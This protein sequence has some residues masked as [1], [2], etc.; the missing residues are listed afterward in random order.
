[1]NEAVAGWMLWS[2]IMVIIVL[3]AL[4]LFLTAADE[5]ERWLRRLR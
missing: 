3:W 1:M 5:I 2:G 4:V